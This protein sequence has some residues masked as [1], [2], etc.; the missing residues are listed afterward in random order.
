MFNIKKRRIEKAIKECIS[1]VG[2]EIDSYLKPNQAA[3]QAIMNDA[4]FV[5]YMEGWTRELLAKHGLKG[6][7]EQASALIGVCRNLSKES[8]RQMSKR[9]L[10]F[11]T[12]E[13]NI[14]FQGGR[15]D[16]TDRVIGVSTGRQEEVTYLL[17]NHLQSFA[18]KQK[19][20]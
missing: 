17:I 2:P 18:N 7:H 19:E 20:I 9:L 13:N 5:G 10:S 11:Y 3:R 16:G 6:C 1:V 14:D 15:R 4:Y 12:D 8:Q